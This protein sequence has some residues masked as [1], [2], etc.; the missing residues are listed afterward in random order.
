M[1]KFLVGQPEGKQPL[2]RP[3][4]RWKHNITSYKTQAGFSTTMSLWC[5][6][7]QMYKTFCAVE[8]AVCGFSVRDLLRVTLM[9]PGILKWLPDFWKI[10]APLYY[11][12]KN[13]R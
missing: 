4:R 11:S 8:L 10:C 2:R 12:Q 1:D 3:W 7:C 5:C 9:A 13:T 6:Y